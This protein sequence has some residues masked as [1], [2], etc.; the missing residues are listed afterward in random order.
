MIKQ[1]VLFLHDAL[2]TSGD[3]RPLM[4][5]IKEQGHEVL[6]FDFSG[7][8]KSSPWPDEFRIDLFARQLETFLKSH[9][10]RD[11]V[12]FGHSMGGYIALYHAAN[13]ENSPVSRI[14]TYGTKFNWGPETVAKETLAL[15]PDTLAERYPEQVK[16][17]HAKHGDRWKV[18]MLS[19]TH[20]IHHLEKLDGLTR[21]DLADVMVPV[22]LMLGDQDRMVTSEETT[23][24]KGKLREADL[25]TISHSKHD[26]ERANLKEI[27]QVILGALV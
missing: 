12:I 3:L 21:E 9:Q 27:A 1:S 10:L 24:T 20:M 19:T 11:V 15:N 8:G 4:D 16:L 2:G 7:H 6:S 14:F 26:L 25:K 23:S 17:L 13:F 18:L 22:T 5:I